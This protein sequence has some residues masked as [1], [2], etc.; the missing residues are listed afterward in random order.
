MDDNI[1]HVK[2]TEDKNIQQAVIEAIARL[3]EYINANLLALNPEKSRVMILTK[4]KQIQKD[5][6]ITVAGKVLTHQPSLTILGN[7]V[8]A[9]LSWEEHVNKLILLSLSN[10]VRTL[11]NISSFMNPEF[12]KNYATAIF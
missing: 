3:E 7:I 2:A 6:Q 1:I 11:R 4:K 8:T 5:F 10:W 12:R 9:D